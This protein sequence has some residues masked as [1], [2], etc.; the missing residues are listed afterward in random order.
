MCDRITNTVVFFFTSLLTKGPLT[1]PV[2]KKHGTIK[3]QRHIIHADDDA[4]FLVNAQT[5]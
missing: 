2:I 3:I 5:A 1:K 4:C